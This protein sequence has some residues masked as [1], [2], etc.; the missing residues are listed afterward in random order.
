MAPRKSDAALTKQLIPTEIRRWSVVY[1][2]RFAEMAVKVARLGATERELAEAIGIGLGV[3]KHWKKRHP[4][5]REALRNA[6]LEADLNVADRLYLR[7]TGYSHPAVKIMSVKHAIRDDDGKLRII[8]EVVHEPYTEHY[9]P[10]TTAAIF[11]LKNRRPDLWK[12][13]TQQDRKVTAEVDLQVSLND[14]REQLS[15]QLNQA[16]RRL[17][18]ELEATGPVIDGE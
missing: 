11:W 1:H 8:D 9:P 7:A 17:F 3:L 6:R 4:E 18:S 2:Q 10:D 13:V 16:S 12:D 14:A 15:A 5:F